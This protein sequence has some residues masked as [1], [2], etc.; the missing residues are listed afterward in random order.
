MTI[1][2]YFLYSPESRPSLITKALGCFFLMLGVTGGAFFLFEAL[3]P[4]VGY[5]ES[6]A[7]ISGALVI[8]SVCFLMIGGRKKPSLQEEAAQKALTFF[9]DFDMEKTLKNNALPL[10]LL[11]LGLGLVLS[12]FKNARPLSEFVKKLR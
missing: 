1:L 8:I 12:Q 9:K 2:D 5:G 11:S 10:S 3:I 4:V 6:G 7:I